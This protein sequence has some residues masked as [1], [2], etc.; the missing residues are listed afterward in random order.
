MFNFKTRSTG[1]EKALKTMASICPVKDEDE[2]EDDN[3]SL[4]EDDADTGWFFECR[5]CKGEKCSG[6]IRK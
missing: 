5:M 2:F 6:Y 3:F 4:E 1:Q